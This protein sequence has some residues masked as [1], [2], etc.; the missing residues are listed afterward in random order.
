MIYHKPSA[1]ALCGLFRSRRRNNR[2]DFSAAGG[3]GNRVAASFAHEAE[4]AE[5]LA[6]ELESAEEI[7]VTA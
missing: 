5:R 3:T 4:Q 1:S 7:E 6:E 2:E